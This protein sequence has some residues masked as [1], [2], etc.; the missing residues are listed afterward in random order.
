MVASNSFWLYL[1]GMFLII[2]V[3]RPSCPALSFARSITYCDLS[4]S[5]RSDRRRRCRNVWPPP[6]SSEPWLP[7]VVPPPP[8][9]PRPR[10]TASCSSTS[11]ACCSR[12]L[13]PNLPSRYHLATTVVVVVVVVVVGG[14]GVGE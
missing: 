11:T 13:P 7:E 2:S 5:E 6:S 14:V 3:V 12:T 4:S 9:P 10:P 1:F 8:P